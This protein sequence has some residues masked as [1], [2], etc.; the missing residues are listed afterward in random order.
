MK[1]ILFATTALIAFGAASAQAAE[2]IKL[3]LGGFATWWTGYATQSDRYTRATGSN[4]TAVDVQGDAEIFFQG[5][6]TLDNG[7]KVGVNVELEAAGGNS[8]T[9]ASGGRDNID[10]SYVTAEGGFGKFIIGTENNGAYLLHVSAPD[11]AGNLDEGAM[12][13][14]QWVVIP[15]A[16]NTPAGGVTLL[17]TTAIDTDNDAEKITYV[18]PSFAGFTVG[19]SYVPD[20][21]TEDDRGVTN[22][23]L[24]GTPNINEAYGVGAAYNNSFGGLG[25]KASVGYVTADVN[26]AGFDQDNEW[27]AGAQLSYAGFTLG[28]AYRSQTLEAANAANRDRDGEAWN[29]GAQYET[30]P[31][32]VSL[33]YFQSVVDYNTVGNAG[34][35]DVVRLWQVSGKYAMGPGVD[36][37]TSIG[38]MT[39]DGQ[40]TVANND[41]KGIAIQT[42]LALAF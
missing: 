22:N 24:V 19:G 36:L 41:N 6:T 40:D 35:K 25:V 11:A 37:L 38:H 13:S 30:G 7:I 12:L 20:A 15:G 4:F 5:S 28:G 9:G 17:T 32:A 39:V 33:G 14:G 18:S 29:V 3:Q 8:E 1:K 21:G 31:F 23:S 10:E 27:T 16:A 42:G 34:A 2:P 26:G